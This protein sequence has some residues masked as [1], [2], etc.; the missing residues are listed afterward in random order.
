M[1]CPY[2]NFELTFCDQTVADEQVAVCRNPECKYAGWRQKLKQTQDALGVAVGKL[3]DIK[4]HYDDSYADPQF[5]NWH[6]VA[7][8]LANDADDAINVITT[9]EQKE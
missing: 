7:Q 8:R 5:V 6:T 3:K 2:C 4:A 9:L 1:K